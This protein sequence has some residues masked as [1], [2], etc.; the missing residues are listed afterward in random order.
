MDPKDRIVKAATVLFNAWKEPQNYLGRILRSIPE[1]SVTE[2][3][4]AVEALESP[5]PERFT[6]EDLAF[7]REL[8][9]LSRGENRLGARLKAQEQEEIDREFPARCEGNTQ[10]FILPLPKCQNPAKAL[11][12][13][14]QDETEQPFEQ[15]NQCLS[16]LADMIQTQIDMFYPYMKHG[17]MYAY[18]PE[19]AEPYTFRI[20][21]GRC[22]K[23]DGQAIRECCS[24]GVVDRKGGG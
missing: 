21:Y 1:P 3:M 9:S 10:A 7:L 11:V 13:W 16:C 5:H 24:F 18:V 15:V 8:L 20:I 14:P 23:C 6:D 19:T 4:H 17:P 22:D 12:W 2:L